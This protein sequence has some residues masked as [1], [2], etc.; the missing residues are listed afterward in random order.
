MYA[1]GAGLVAPGVQAGVGLRVPTVMLSQF[2]HERADPIVLNMRSEELFD[3]CAGEREKY[4][5]NEIDWGCRAFDVEQNSARAH[6]V[7]G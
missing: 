3:V 6:G 4:L 5:V 7:E 1:L 2:V